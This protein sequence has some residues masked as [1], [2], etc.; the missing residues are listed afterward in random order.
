MVPLARR[1]RTIHEITLST[2]KGVSKANTEGGKPQGS[3]D[4]SRSLNPNQ[5]DP[6]YFFVTK[7]PW[8]VHYEVLIS[9]I[10]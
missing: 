8:F 7:E 2:T 6:T 3:S 10:Q 5:R 1:N 9:K 4:K